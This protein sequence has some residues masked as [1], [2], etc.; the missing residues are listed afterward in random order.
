MNRE[1]I[2][3]SLLTCLLAVASP[4]SAQDFSK[5]PSP[6]VGGY[7]ASGFGGAGKMYMESYF[8]PR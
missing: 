3:I 4:A 7:P 6:F 5:Y 1:R 8:P 2:R